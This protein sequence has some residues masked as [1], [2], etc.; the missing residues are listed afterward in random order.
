LHSRELAFL[1]TAK[2]I[3]RFLSGRVYRIQGNRFNNIGTSN[4][5]KYARTNW[6]AISIIIPSFNQAA[7]VRQ[8]LDSIFSQNYPQLETIVLDPGSTDGSR[9]ILQEYAHKIT[10]LILE[11]DQG[12]SDALQRGL[13][14]ASGEI[15]TW[16]CAD[17]MLEPN[18]LFYFAD[19]F[20]RYHSDIVAGGCRRVDEQ[21][22][23]LE[24][25]FAAMPFNK[26][27][28]LDILDMLDVLHGWQ[29][30]HFYYQP[31]VFF[32]KNIWRRAGGFLHKSAYYGMDYDMW[33]RMALAGA[34]G[35]QLPNCLAASR[36]QENQK[37]QL[38]QKPVYLWQALNYLKHYYQIIQ[39]AEQLL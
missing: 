26:V 32:T 7:F 39:A 13:N 21:G 24:V 34:I 25:H 12:Q 29:A 3:W 16:L 4:A 14:L 19:A 31:E 36:A 5:M 15:L 11:P 30:G 38:G 6:P 22:R 23:E 1:F 37:T 18:S 20:M 2:S 17:D 9:E 10:R 28:R 33:V 8:A 35:V 27:I